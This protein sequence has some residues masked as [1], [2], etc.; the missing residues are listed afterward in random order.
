MKYS[1]RTLGD[2]AAEFP[3]KFTIKVIIEYLPD[4]VLT[5]S[6][7]MIYTNDPETAADQAVRERGWDRLPG[8]KPEDVWVDGGI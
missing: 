5:D 2:M 3:L 6:P 4:G 8:F 1:T 7:P